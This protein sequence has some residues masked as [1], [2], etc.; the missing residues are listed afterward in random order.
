M[1]GP[2]PCRLRGAFASARRRRGVRARRAVLEPGRALCVRVRD[3]VCIP[4]LRVRSRQGL[5]AAPDALTLVAAGNLVF[6]LALRF[7]D[8]MCTS[9]AHRRHGRQ[10]GVVAAS[11][12][13]CWGGR[14]RAPVGAA[15][16]VVQV[17]G[18]RR[19]CAQRL[20][21]LVQ[22]AAGR[23]VHLRTTGRRR[24]Q[25][26][27]VQSAGH[28]PRFKCPVRRHIGQVLQ[29]WWQM[30]ARQTRR[31]PCLPDLTGLRRGHSTIS[32]ETRMEDILHYAT[33]E[34]PGAAGGHE[35]ER[36]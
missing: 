20:P 2:A 21:H 24:S 11:P 8:D 5:M 25:L 6:Q 27:F 30:R 31:T 34:S 12:G 35:A 15:L 9:D 3:R 17:V 14:R 19:R 13:S 1:R 28:P 33:A 4:N 29:V 23:R 32:S 36:G 18:R 16:E 26:R 10:S 7:C 22:R